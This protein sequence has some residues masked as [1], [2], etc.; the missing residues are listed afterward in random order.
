MV[1]PLV[2]ETLRYGPYSEAW[3][4]VN[5][6]P[7]QWGSKRTGPDLQRVGGKYPNLWHYKHLMDPRQV[8]QKS[9][10]PSYAFLASSTLDYTIIEK[11]VA[12]MQRLGV[13]YSDQDREEAIS[14]A[15]AEAEV[16]AS[17]LKQSGVSLSRDTE[18]TA[19]I[20]Y[21]QRLGTDRKTLNTH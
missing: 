21:L 7:F 14:H 19:L 3:E 4:Y 2:S 18:M 6:H 17:D 8:S 5:D 10:M 1:R 12:L 15:T 11:K 9:N 20:S 13:A 16:I